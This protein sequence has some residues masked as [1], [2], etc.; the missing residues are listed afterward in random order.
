[1]SCITRVMRFSFTISSSCLFYKCKW[2]D[3]HTL[4]KKKIHTSLFQGSVHMLNMYDVRFWHHILRFCLCFFISTHIYYKCMFYWKNG[5]ISFLIQYQ[6]W[7]YWPSI[8]VLFIRRKLAV[9]VK[10][11]I[12]G[13]RQHYFPG[14]KLKKFHLLQFYIFVT[15][16][17][18]AF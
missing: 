9:D 7:E 16:L 10:W 18:L 17:N 3:T 13:E 11:L 15:W 1:M 14:R 6:L 8:Q 5:I 12:G 2:N 4:T